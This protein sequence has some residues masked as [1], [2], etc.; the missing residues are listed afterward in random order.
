MLCQQEHFLSNPEP[1]SRLHIFGMPF[2]IKTQPATHRTC[3]KTSP[4]F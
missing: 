4:P 3:A 2:L 1:F